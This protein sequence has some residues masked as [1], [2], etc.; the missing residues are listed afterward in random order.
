MGNLVWGD[1]V[2]ASHDL[3]R[4][5]GVRRKGRPSQQSEHLA[6]VDSCDQRSAARAGD[7]EDGGH[8]RLR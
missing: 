5:G 2:T 3:E 1:T 6:F 8:Q 4:P 7:S